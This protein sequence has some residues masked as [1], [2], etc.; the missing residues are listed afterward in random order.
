LLILPPTA[1][2]VIPRSGAVS[3][4][5]PA[6]VI[7][8]RTPFA[9]PARPWL[10]APVEPPQAAASKPNPPQIASVAA[11]GARSLDDRNAVTSGI[12]AGRNSDI[13]IQP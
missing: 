1:L 7:N 6:G 11:Q 9:A 5:L 3:V 4:A 10:A 2:T 8:N 13:G 12:A